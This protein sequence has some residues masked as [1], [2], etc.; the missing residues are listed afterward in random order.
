M[1]SRIKIDLTAMYSI[2]FFNLNLSL[3]T[4]SY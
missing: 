2:V 1:Y 4:L 3:S